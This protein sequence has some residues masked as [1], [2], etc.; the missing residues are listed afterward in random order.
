MQI[1]ATNKAPIDSAAKLKTRM[2]QQLG[3]KTRAGRFFEKL[4]LRT[5]CLGFGPLFGEAVI[6]NLV[7]KD[8]D[9]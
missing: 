3:A 4:L 7:D 9:Y 2:E 5:L 1:P 8:L 6:N